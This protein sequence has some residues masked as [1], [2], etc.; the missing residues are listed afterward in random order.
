LYVS[1]SHSGVDFR[2]AVGTPV[3][4]AA[5]GTVQGTGNTDLTC[6][7]ASVCKWVFIVHNNGLATAYGHLSVIKAVS[8]ETVKAGDLIGYSGQTGHATGPHLHITVYA[9]NGINGEEGARVAQRPAAACKGKTYTMPLA[10]TSAYLDPLLYLPHAT[11][12]MFKDG[13]SDFGE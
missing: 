7:R 9:A 4:A 6:P 10:P 5:D 12:S 1:G 3:Y 11:A 13:T 2:A 8:G